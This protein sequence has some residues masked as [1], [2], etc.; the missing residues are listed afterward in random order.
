MKD[1][2]IGKA[3]Y[4][5]DI[6]TRNVAFR[7]VTCLHPTKPE[8]WFQ[9]SRLASAYLSGKHKKF[10]V[11][12]L[13]DADTD[14]SL[15]QYLSRPST[16]CISFSSSILVFPRDFCFPT[17]SLEARKSRSCRLQNSKVEQRRVLHAAH[18]PPYTLHFL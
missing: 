3:L 13:Y 18:H 4:S 11:P 6:D 15:Q 10:T 17:S 5:L 1:D 16:S 14:S 2:H 12:R 9:M 8:M 7:Y